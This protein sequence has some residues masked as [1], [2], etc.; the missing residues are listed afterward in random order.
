MKHSADDI[1]KLT[2][3]QHW[4]GT[5]FVGLPTDSGTMTQRAI[6][7]LDMQLDTEPPKKEGLHVLI[8]V[9]YGSEWEVECSRCG[10]GVFELYSREDAVRLIKSLTS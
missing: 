3:F 4:L 1:R 6:A 9:Y 2:A 7:Y 5:N 10:K 8:D